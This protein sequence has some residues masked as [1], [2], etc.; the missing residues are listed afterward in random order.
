MQFKVVFAA[1][2]SLN[3]HKPITA[4]SFAFGTKHE[5]ILTFY[6]FL[7]LLSVTKSRSCIAINTRDERKSKSLENQ[8]PK[9]S[10]A[11]LAKDNEVVPLLLSQ[12]FVC[13]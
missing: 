7:L 1:R 13:D 4:S 12:F 3:Y 5:L 2:P 9:S 8:P 11:M 10:A 6:Y